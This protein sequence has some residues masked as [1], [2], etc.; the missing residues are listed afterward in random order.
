MKT[1][2]LLNCFFLAVA[3]N[4]TPVFINFGSA[5][6]GNLGS[7]ATFTGGGFSVVA[8]ADPSGYNNDLYQKMAG[9][10][11]NGLG[12]TSDPSGDHEITSGHYIQLNITQI[13]GDNPLSIGME[14][15]TGDDGW[16][17]YETNSANTNVYNLTGSGHNGAT[18]LLSGSTE[19][20]FSLGT[21]ADT[22]IDVTATSGNVLLSELDFNK[23]SSVPEPASFML[24]GFGLA[25]L[26]LLRRGRKA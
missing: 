14:S 11:E 21:V 23:T 1:T 9:G 2:I 17:I 4:A 16:A 26:G 24:G 12:L 8:T 22:Y 3:A 10:D 18:L 13:L 6:G 20:D 25:A 19:G 7:T 5:A 15:S